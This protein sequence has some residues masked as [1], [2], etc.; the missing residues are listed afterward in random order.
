MTPQQSRTAAY[1]LT[2]IVPAALMGGAL[3]S[4]FV[5]GLY[6]C[7]MCWWQR[8]PHIAA[9]VLALLAL[10]MK[11]KGSG[12]LSVTLAAIAIG[13][14]GLIGGFHAGVEYGWWEGVTA[15]STVAGGGNP[16]DAIMNA[17][18]VRCDVAPWDLF[19]ISLAGFN[20][21]ISMTGAIL[22]FALLGKGRKGT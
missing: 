21:L 10:T 16:L 17:P 5:F 22:V 18:V 9:I 15:C 12:D 3:I 20:F 6:P 14:S 4:Q 13:I 8:Y 2:L 7:Q 19:G 11:G 1:A